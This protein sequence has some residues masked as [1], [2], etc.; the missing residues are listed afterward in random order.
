M[1][2]GGGGGGILKSLI[3]LIIGPR[4]L[5]W[6]NNLLE[7]MVC[8]SFTGVKFDLLLLLGGHVGSSC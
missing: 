6:E 1:K 4:G 7:I 3:S 2:G 5:E 8:K